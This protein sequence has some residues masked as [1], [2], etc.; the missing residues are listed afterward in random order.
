MTELQRSTE[1]G[2]MDPPRRRLLT[3]LAGG[4][5]SIWAAGFAW[6]V[7]S[8]LR[9]PH[10]RQS[11]GQRTLN[12]G[13]LE[14]LPVGHGRLVRNRSEP[15]YVVHTAESKLVALSAVCTHLHCILNFDE[16]GKRMVC[17]CHAAS[18]DLNG[19]VLDG[20][21]PRPLRRFNVETRLG[22]IVV[23]TH[24]QPGGEA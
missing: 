7:G 4:F 18:F 16:A 24:R 21:A 3:W 20:P 10:T 5:L 12:A 9:P 15:I 17:P 19:N 2:L 11:L 23:H 1:E 8:F 6:V 13:S 22:E 14:S